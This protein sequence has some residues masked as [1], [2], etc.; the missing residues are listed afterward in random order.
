M[1]KVRMLCVALG[2]L[3]LLMLL[4]PST[5]MAADAKAGA[6]D[7]QILMGYLSL[8]EEPR[9]PLSPTEKPIAEE[10]L[11]GARVGTADDN[12]TGRLLKQ[13]YRLDEV[14]V[15]QGGPRTAEDVKK[16]AHD[17]I[18]SGHNY[19][20]VDLPAELLLQVADL[21][22]AKGTMIFNVRAA[23]DRLRGADCRDNIFHTT[24]NRAMLADAL[25]QY[26]IKMRWSK[27]FLVVGQ[28]DQD[29]L[30]A[31]AIKRSAK[32]Y[33]AKIVIE[34]EWTFAA[35]SKRTDDGHMSEQSTVPTFTQGP[36]YDVVIVADEADD[37]GEFL[38]YHTYIPRPVAG[39]HGLTPTAWYRT[40]EAW[41]ATQFHNRFE[42]VAKRWMTNRDYAAWVAV[43]TVGEAVTRLS[44]ADLSKVRPFVLSPD[45]AISAFMGT[46]ASY[47]PWD[48][49]LRQQIL[50][51]GAKMLV[52]FSPQPGFLHEFDT[53]DTL[54]FDRPDSACKLSH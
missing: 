40:N 46:G 54:G 20:V 15:P 30:Y 1:F 34:K 49:Q 25:A 35:G 41:G 50:L 13:N 2:A 27:W 11:I 48:H 23:D 32:R 31:Q 3:L 26:L 51:T 18:S 9:E 28:T 8:Q 4:P 24:P 33:N 44:S 12:T 7:L 22:E 19:L 43:R 14:I 17:L 10:G 16:A 42:R 29:K 53:L 39:T 37:F 21:P 52:S 45:F 47:R 5:G 36:D 38:P 6:G